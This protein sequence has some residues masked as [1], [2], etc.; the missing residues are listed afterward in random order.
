M[1]ATA[2]VSKS[3]FQTV[4]VRLGRD[5]VGLTLPARAAVLRPPTANPLPDAAAAVRDSLAAPIESAPLRQRIQQAG[6][7][8][9][10]I[11]ISDITRPVPNELVVS[12][13]LETLNAAGVRDEQVTILIATGMHRSS[14]AA[15]RVLMLGEALLGRC[16]VIDHCAEAAA[17]LAPRGG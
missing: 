3:E 12:A 5:Y 1:V 2:S 17:E 9:V 16:R 11:T 6:R 13:L 7:C 10:V 4:P 14:T 8:S 15:E